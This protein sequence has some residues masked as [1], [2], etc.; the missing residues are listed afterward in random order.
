[1][2]KFLWDLDLDKIPIGWENVYQDSLINNPN[3]NTIKL[4][5]S[6]Y[7]GTVTSED[8]FSHPIKCKELIYDL[9]NKYKSEAK[10][11]YE[12]QDKYSFKQVV[13]ELFK[14]DTLLFHL[15]S[16][17]VASDEYHEDT[18]F[19]PK[20]YETLH[21]TSLISCYLDSESYDLDF[22]NKYGKY[23]LINFL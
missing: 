23:R 9:F 21:E 13:N 19:N 7:D 16:D 11:L 14:L 22:I 4:F 12:N 6:N 17:W 10:E 2:I 20:D 3:G 8:Y 18:I 5:S 1:M 15:L